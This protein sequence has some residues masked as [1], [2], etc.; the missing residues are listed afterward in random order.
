[1]QLYLQT[2]PDNQ[3]VKFY[4]LILQADLLGGWHLIRQWGWQGE[5]G[6]SKRHYYD[7]YSEAM[8]AISYWRDRQLKRGFILVFVSGEDS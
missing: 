2:P 7:D 5:R 4:Q 3:G 8:K 6:S 1:M